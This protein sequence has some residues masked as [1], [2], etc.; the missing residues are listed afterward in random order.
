MTDRK[1]WEDLTVLQL[2]EK[3]LS[4]NKTLQNNIQSTQDRSTILINKARAWRKKIIELGGE[5]PGEP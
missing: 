1:E 4:E 3:V 2:L 5:D